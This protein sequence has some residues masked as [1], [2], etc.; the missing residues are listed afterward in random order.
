MDLPPLA[1]GGATRRS[2]D[3]YLLIH[4]QT[5]SMDAVTGCGD[6][7]TGE[8]LTTIDLPAKLRRC[9]NELLQFMA[10]IYCHQ[11]FA[12]ILCPPCLKFAL[13]FGLCRCL[14]HDGLASTRGLEALCQINPELSLE[15]LV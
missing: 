13:H 15:F 9:A 8:E 5:T 11:C 10:T 12:L 6:K 2:S 14:L 4:A 1:V 7:F 3:V